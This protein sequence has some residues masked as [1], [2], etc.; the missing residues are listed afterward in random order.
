MQALGLSPERMQK[1]WLRNERAAC[2]DADCLR[3]LYSERIRYL[4]SLVRS[5]IAERESV[6]VEADP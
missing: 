6:R 4:E 3:G 2:G 5:G 1:A